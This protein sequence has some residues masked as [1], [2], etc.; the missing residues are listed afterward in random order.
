MINMEDKKAVSFHSLLQ[1]RGSHSTFIMNIFWLWGTL[2]G[3]ESLIAGFAL[4]N[5]EP[6]LVNSITSVWLPAIVVICSAMSILGGVIILVLS[7]IKAIKI[8]LSE[9]HINPYWIDFK[10]SEFIKK[11]KKKLGE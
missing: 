11:L 5:Y 10:Q 3:A 2:F 6:L 7:S 4:L 9:P 1:V 8:L